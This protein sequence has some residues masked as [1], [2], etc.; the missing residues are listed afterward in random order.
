MKK[1][2]LSLALTFSTMLSTVWAYDFSVVVSSGHTLY[3]N[4]TS[5]SGSYTAEVTY[6]GSESYGNYYSG[7]TKPAGNLIIPS[8][9]TYNGNTYSVTNIGD[10]A[11]R[12]CSGLTSVIIPNSV[13]S[14]GYEA[15]NYGS[16]IISVTIP[17]SVTSINDSAFS[18]CS[19]LTSITIPNNVTYI[20][21]KAFKN[22]TSLTSITIPNNVT[23]IG[24]EV[25]CDCRNLTTLNFNA[26][27]CEYDF[28]VSE[29][30]TSR[31]HPFYN[32][33][34][35]TI[36]I[37]NSVQNMPSGFA[38][39]FDSLTSI[40]IPKYITMI[41]DSA[42][43]YCR[44]LTSITISNSATSIG[45]KAFKNCSSL[46]SITIPNNVTYIGEEAFGECRNL[47]TLNF[48]AINCEY[49]LTCGLFTREY[50]HPFYNCP[51]STINVG[52][53][54]QRIPSNFAYWLHTLTNLS[55]GNNVTYIGNSAFD[56]CVNLTNVVIPSSVD[57]IGYE[58]FECCSRLV[59]VT[60]PNNVKYLAERCF[61]S[62]SSL[63]S[64]VI[65]NSVTYLGGYAFYDC[66]NLSLVNIPNSVTYIGYNAFYQVNSIIYSGIATGAPWG[67]NMMYGCIEGDFA[68]SDSTKTVL[69]KYLGSQ[70]NV[71][72]PNT[73]TTIGY[74]AFNG[75]NNLT[76]VTIP[77]SV[78]SIEN[79]A[80]GGCTSLTTLNFNAINCNDFFTYY[81]HPFANCPITTINIGDSAQRI[82]S[83]FASYLT[84]LSS[85]TMGNSVASIGYSAFS[86]CSNLSSITIP[87]GVTII[88]DNTFL[89]CIALT[90]INIPSSV[91][92][93]GNSAFNGCSSLASITMHDSIDYIGTFAFAS[94]AYY[95][96]FANWEGNLL[97]LNNWLI[98]A[99]TSSNG[100][101][102][103]KDSIRGVAFNVFQNCIV[104]TINSESLIPPIISGGSTGLGINNL[105]TVNVSCQALSAYLSNHDWM[106]LNVQAIPY[107]VELSVNDADMG[108]VSLTNNT[109]NSTMFQA[110][111]NIGYTFQSWSDGNTQNPR[112]VNV[113]CDTTFTAIFASLRTVTVLSSNISMGTVIGGG[114]YEMDSLATVVAIPTNGY[115]F[116]NWSDNSTVNP[117]TFAVTSNT[118]LIAYF[119]AIVPDTTFINI[120]DTTY[121]PVHDTTIVT[122][123]DT[124][125]NTVHD[126]T[127]I[128]VPVHDT[129]IITHIDTVINTVHDTTYIN[130][131]VHDTTI[132]TQ[133]DTVIN[134]VHDTTY[135]NV[136][137]HDTTII[138]QIDTITITNTV[139]DTV[140]NT[141]HDTTYI[142]VPVHD[143][144]IITQTDTIINTVH[145]TITT[146][147]YDTIDNFIYDT[148][149]L[150]ETD[151]LWLFD[152]VYLH[153]T[154]YIHDTIYITDST[155]GIDDVAVINAR[156][157]SSHSRIVVEGADGNNVMLFD[158]SGRL[159]AT[160]R[161]EYSRLEFEVPISGAY[162]VKIGNY[163]AQKIVVIK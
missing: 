11:F 144:T 35:S 52:N 26:I 43:A 71:T 78:T 17:N 104:R 105:F 147:L 30:D 135:V 25:F 47:T 106:V 20:G 10:Y 132:I 108:S 38:H 51:I 107:T 152:T 155:T 109:C 66:N 29:Y 137:V 75:C 114:E 156:V 28:L 9:V 46:T 40:I 126:T 146:T 161:D 160:K 86:G 158:M 153:A 41:R 159:L 94:T 142:N 62:C 4:I 131:P 99:R 63:T 149:Y 15:F 154:I 91:T 98:A 118:Q 16:S 157:Y 130:V 162:F 136:P 115:R 117:Y 33:P 44:N 83:N 121:V 69:R 59:S 68:Y 60:I 124:V 122:Q 1:V 13:T 150:T 128:N 96:N 120:H 110:F 112:F 22:C 87:N 163:K 145:D 90:S 8:S 48:N 93:I 72:I 14:I 92:S 79:G 70:S 56:S 31:R 95:E 18:H 32:C 76:S 3:F 74:S 140:I 148:V 64:V 57:T 7:Y 102:I 55:I 113:T 12:G 101:Y 19:N 138:T 23:Y 36:N 65:P 151:T 85:V 100:E 58:A 134:T 5:N 53:S 42:F 141:V 89:D 133:I 54:V 82:P 6:P 37:G 123:I 84:S 139:F 50:A 125:I 34:I 88:G 80:F 129:T 45:T 81:S 39:G 103:I 143:T 67:A 61:K 127:Y 73:V 116:T 27:N 24:E 49:L 21:R 77:S 97:Y 119:E 111:P 2:L